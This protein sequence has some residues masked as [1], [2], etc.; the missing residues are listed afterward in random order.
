MRLRLPRLALVLAAA[1]ALTGLIAGPAAAKRGTKL[2]GGATTLAVPQ[3]TA[4][5]LGGAGYALAPVAPATVDG[6]TFSFPITKGRVKQRGSNPFRFFRRLAR[7][8]ATVGH[9]GGL[10]ITKGDKTVTATKLRILV[11]GRRGAIVA[12]INDKRPL[13][14]ATLANVVIKD[15]KGTAEAKL[16]GAAARALRRAFSDTTTWTRGI[17]LG[18]VTVAP[19]TA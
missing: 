14:I 16:S 3:A 11:R 2:T 15:G 8:T 9:D 19:T 1:L 5:A 17:P 7:R 4:D 13:T 6:T 10:S 12:R 18:V